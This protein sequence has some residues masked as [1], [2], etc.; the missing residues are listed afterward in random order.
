MK[1]LTGSLSL[2]I[3]LVLMASIG[4]A[5]VVDSGS[6]VFSEPNGFY[7]RV[8]AFI[9]CTHDDVANPVPGAPGELTYVYT[10]TN[11]PGSF[12]AII[13]FNI[14]A[15]IG[16]VSSAGV[17]SDAYP[18]TPAPSAVINND[19]GV[20]RWDWADPD[21]IAPGQV[22][23]QLFIVS[24]YSPGTLSDTV[25]SVEGNSPLRSKALALGR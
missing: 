5:A 23:E 25:F 15:P 2:A 3:A 24:A 17:V 9:V 12:I 1:K 22:S 11:D 16:T 14:D 19:D 4:H 10:I 13:G 7:T 20:V 21:L 6:S 18:A 8:K